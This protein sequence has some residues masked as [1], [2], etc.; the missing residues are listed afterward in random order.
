MKT[1]FIMTA[2][3]IS[4]T[5]LASNITWKDRLFCYGKAFGN[6]KFVVELKSSIDNDGLEREVYFAKNINSKMTLVTNRCSKS[7]DILT[8]QNNDISIEVDVGNR[9]SNGGL[10]DAAK[11]IYHP[12]KVTK[13]GFFSDKTEE[14]RCRL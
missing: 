13:R 8:C 12:T 10:W 14:I 11:Y 5:T 7:E 2:F 4:T 3:L 9:Y 6:S 1:F